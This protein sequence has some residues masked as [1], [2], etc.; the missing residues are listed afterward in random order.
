MKRFL[1]TSIGR[2]GTKYIS[3][4]FS[5]SGIYCSWEKSFTINKHDIN[6]N[7]GSNG[8][9]V[10]WL[11]APYIFQLPAGTI[12][13]HQTRNPLVWLNSWLKV[14]PQWGQQI[15]N[16]VDDNCGFYRWFDGYHPTVDM[17]LYVNWNNMIEAAAQDPKFTYIRYKLE[18]INT[19]KIIELAKLIESPVNQTDILQAIN[20]LGKKVNSSKD[21]PLYVPVTWNT[22]P[23]GPELDDFKAITLKYGYIIE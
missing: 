20:K 4:L 18:D 15:T 7:I 8:G 1:V 12:I 14:T 11:A 21:N 13:L 10:S 22:L 23:T 16:F 3:K 17:K 9:E 2:S 19:N 6:W 5:E